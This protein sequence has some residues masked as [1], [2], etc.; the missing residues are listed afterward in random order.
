MMLEHALHQT[1]QI[2][3]PTVPVNTGGTGRPGLGGLRPTTTHEVS[4]R[5]GGGGG[6]G[7]FS[8]QSGHGPEEGVFL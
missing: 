8:A 6:G 2:L 5:A 7:P 1:G 4:Q 3:Y